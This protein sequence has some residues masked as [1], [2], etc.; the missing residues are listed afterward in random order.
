[1]ASTSEIHSKNFDNNNSFKVNTL[2]TCLSSI[3]TKANT[4]LI[5]NTLR[6]FSLIYKHT[7]IATREDKTYIKKCYFYRY[8][9][10]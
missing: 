7:Y 9:S 5:L 4:N 10:S 3:K 2:S 1:M 8:Y 6:Q